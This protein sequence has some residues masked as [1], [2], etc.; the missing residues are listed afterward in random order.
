MRAGSDEQNHHECSDSNSAP[1][2]DR[3]AARAVVSGRRGC[4]G[5]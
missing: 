4:C 2:R 3:P 1:V 5:Q